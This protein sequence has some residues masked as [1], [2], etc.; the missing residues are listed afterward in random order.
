MH[1]LSEV[2]AYYERLLAGAADDREAVG[3][4]TTHAQDVAL[5]SLTRVDGLGD[6]AR[7]LDVG[8]GLGALKDLFDRRGW[9]IDY[10][11]VD[12]SP[13]MIERA[14]ARH[15]DARFEVRDI[16]RDPPAGRFDFVLSSGALTF[17][18]ADQER[19]V[20]DMIRAMYRACDVAVAFNMLCRHAYVTSGALQRGAGDADYVSPERALAF[21]RRLS[22]HVALMHDA[23]GGRFDVF[24]YKRNRGAL[25]RYLAEARPPR[26]WSPALRAAVEYHLELGLYAELL[27]LL[28]DVAP[29]AGVLTYRGIAHLGL[30]DAARAVA[31]FEQAIGLDPS[32]P[33]PHVHLATVAHRTRRPNLA[34][35]HLRRAVAAAPERLEPREAL[36]RTLL[37]LGR[38]PEA[39]EALA[40][41][42]AGPLRDL[43]A[44]LAS[45]D[46]TEARG[47]LERSLAAAPDQLE[48]LSQLARLHERTGDLD[49]ALET[50]HRAHRVSPDDRSIDHRIASLVQR[51]AGPPHEE[52][53]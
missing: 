37:G 35:A 42:P 16:L 18:V 28:A 44:A 22:R 5:L 13:A 33:E 11:G 36:V 39:R 19:Y 20:A 6:G 23:D 52:T 8:C 2:I 45:H 7:V 40:P 50:W 25:A 15:P 47:L 32:Q 30:G 46:P 53:T 31:A 24:V 4:R 21:C 10:T 51:R 41:L 14:R 34:V 9:T 43:L 49:A 26:T 12:I 48:A 27:D 3:W 29:A 1:D 17:R 38:D